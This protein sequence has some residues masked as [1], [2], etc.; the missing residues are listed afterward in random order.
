MPSTSTTVQGAAL[1]RAAAAISAALLPPA[2]SVTAASHSSDLPS[3]LPDLACALASRPAALSEVLAAMTTM[4][5]D[6]GALRH[7]PGAC[8]RYQVLC[9]EAPI[10]SA[11][12]TWAAWRDRPRYST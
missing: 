4:I 10:A 7:H 5:A 8:W 11:P 9:S 3:T 2:A 6:K 1:A 12:R